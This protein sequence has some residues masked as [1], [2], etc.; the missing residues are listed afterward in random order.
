MRHQPRFALFV[1]LFACAGLAP[2]QPHEPAAAAIAAFSGDVEPARILVKFRD[3][4]HVTA[5]DG[6]LHWARGE[7]APA[8]RAAAVKS[9]APHHLAPGD[10][11]ERQR[12]L[13]QQY[14]NV[15]LPDLRLEFIAL[16][17]PGADLA[18]AIDAL[19][20]DPAVDYALPVPRPAAPPFPPNYRNNQG[21]LNNPAVGIGGSEF[22]TWPGG[23][24]QHVRVCDIEYSWNYSHQDLPAMTHLGLPPVD[25]FGSTNHGTA[26]MGVIGSRS[27]S[28]GTTGAVYH[29]ALYT[30]A[31]NTAA[32]FSVAS[33][34][35]TAAAG[36]RPGDAMLIEQQMSGPNG[37]GIYVPV[38]W[39]RPTYNAIRQAVGAGVIVVE[40]AGNGGEN[41][42]API[43]STGNGGH[44]PFLLQNDSGAI[45]VGAGAA[46]ASFGGSNTDR[47]RLSFSCYGATVDLQGWGERVTTTGYG[48]L[49]S[50]EGVNYYYTSTFNGTSSATP[51]VTSAACALQSIHKHVTL[52]QLLTPA[53]VRDLL[54]A[55]GSPQQS[56]S[57]PASQ[58]IGPRPNVPAA[59]A[60][61][62]GNR[63]CNANSR[64][65]A[66][67]IAMGASPDLNADGI[68]DECQC[69][70]DFNASG[71]VPDDAD[72]TA[73]F[74]AWDAGQPA[75]DVNG[76]GGTPDDADVVHFFDLWSAGC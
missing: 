8:A 32:G 13:A 66:I 21:Y 69:P 25:P 12:A 3:G 29:A 68:P 40:A 38:E 15:P 11:L 61:L 62:F 60:L 52:G 5:A 45:I 26:V 28:W 75:A 20:A 71:G 6:R 34:V 58:H 33:A 30:A 35:T 41:L 63:D 14:W 74:L 44:Y 43:F 7:A 73:F 72:V 10:E 23:T 54:V 27:N 55:T 51:V 53:Q 31:A 16:L 70:G 67:D 37:S 24:G 56:G 36:L 17:A 18:A 48:G 57:N 19:R 22:Q 49:Y 1:A 9:W 64:P 39:Y 46:P 76:S 4:M 2:G 42:D 65:D 47:S 50:A 59:V